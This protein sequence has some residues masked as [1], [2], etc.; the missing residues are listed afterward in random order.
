MPK[1]SLRRTKCLLPQRKFA[2]MKASKYIVILI[3]ALPNMAIGEAVVAA[4]TIRSQT[5]LLASDVILMEK[6]IPDAVTRVSEVVGLEAKVVLYEG[7]S[8]SYSDIGPA[9]VIERNQIV[10]LM[11]ASG[12]LL[13]STEARSL[14]RAGVGDLLRVMNLSS[15]KT[16]AGIVSGNGSVIVGGNSTGVSR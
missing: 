11:F 6:D 13:I 1:S 8:I 2:D 7:R 4:R 14:G 15:R 5:I 9:A 12:E 10:T 16:V 3:A